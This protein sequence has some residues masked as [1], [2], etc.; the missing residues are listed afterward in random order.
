VSQVLW[1][2]G[3]DATCVA[4]KAHFGQ[5][6]PV[7]VPLIQVPGEIPSALSSFHGR[8]TRS[9][10][11]F[12]FRDKLLLTSRRLSSPPPLGKLIEIDAEHHDHAD[13]DRLVV[14]IDIVDRQTAVQNTNQQS[15]CERAEDAS[16]SAE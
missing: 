9:S 13:D 6:C 5:R 1:A 2:I 11:R 12:P 7:R 14:R 10:A 8:S 3:P 15:S 4:G 16:F